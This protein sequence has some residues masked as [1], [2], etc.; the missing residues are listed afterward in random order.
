MRDPRCTELRAKI[1][2]SAEVA[3]LVP[4]GSA[5]TQWGGTRRRRTKTRIIRIPEPLALF[6]KLRSRLIVL[7]CR[8]GFLLA[9]FLEILAGCSGEF[10]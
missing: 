3:V 4:K 5:H 8:V 7:S 10:G 2:N 6:P 9:A 1:N